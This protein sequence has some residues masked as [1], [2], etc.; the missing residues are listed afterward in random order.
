MPKAGV[1]LP[2]ALAA[3]TDLDLIRS[4]FD[5]SWVPATALPSGAA[6]V[7]APVVDAP[8]GPY[9]LVERRPAGP[10]VFAGQL[11]FPGGRIE[12]GD[13]DPLAAAL[14][15][16]EEEVGFRP[17]AVEVVGHLTEM[18]NHL[19]RRVVAFVGIVPLAA[20]P[21]LP[22]SPAE[23]AEL[24]LIPL[25][26]L[27]QPGLPLDPAAPAAAYR[28]VSY[29]SRFVPNREAALHYWHLE[30]GNG[31]ARAV[32][33]GLTGEMVARMLHRLYDWVPPSPPK[34]IQDWEGLRP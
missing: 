20:I 23:V 6:S 7:L 8:G 1:L 14:R 29:E 22:A 13:A 34:P 3:A 24:I 4:A 26:G 32:L 9:L 5:R 21:A 11:G 27:R 12:S 2:R 25:R 31:P 18:D 17:E 28:P 19:G 10:S 16:A 30:Q 33:W 15:E